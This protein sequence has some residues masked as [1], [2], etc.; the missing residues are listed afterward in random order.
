MFTAVE[1]NAVEIGQF[2]F[3]LTENGSELYIGGTDTSLYTGSI[4]FHPVDQS[5]GVY[6]LENATVFVDGMEV[7]RG[8]AT[9][10]DSGTSL[11]AAT[12]SVAR[13][14]YAQIP[15]TKR[16]DDGGQGLYVLPCGA[17]ATISF[18]WGGK[19]WEVP[20]SQ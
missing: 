4:E 9:V 18:S 13:A 11:M 19:I 7:G 8:I 2:A 1:Q 15:G 12:P 10:I 3:K 14:I 20:S 16:Q 17:T 6:A 5:Q